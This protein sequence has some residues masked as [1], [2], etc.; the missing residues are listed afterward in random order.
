[1]GWGY[2]SLFTWSGFLVM[3][4][5]PTW[6]RKAGIPTAPAAILSGLSGVLFFYVWTNFGVWVTDSWGMYSRDLTGLML[7]Y[8]NG[9]PFLRLQMTS[10]LIFVPAGV[11]AVELI[12]NWGRNICRVRFAS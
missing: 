7:A 9:L 2:I 6:W 5:L 4:A 10:T 8:V 1:L 12:R 3:V 11:A